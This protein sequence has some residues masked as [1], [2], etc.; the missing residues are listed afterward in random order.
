M[1]TKKRPNAKGHYLIAGAILLAGCAISGLILRWGGVIGTPPP[2][3]EEGSAAASS[4]E[5]PET[6][7]CAVTFY[8]W[9]SDPLEEKTVAQGAPVLPPVLEEENVLF[10]GWSEDLYAVQEDLKVVP[11]GE[12]VAEVTNALCADS[13]YVSGKEP[14]R[15][16]LR[17]EGQ[18]DCTDFVIT[19]AYDAD[20]L[21]FEGLENALPTLVAKND[22]ATGEL[23]LTNTGGQHLRAPTELGKLIFRCTKDGGYQTNLPKTVSEIYTE[24]NGSK[25]YTDSTAYDTNVYILEIEKE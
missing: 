18:V 14:F 10:K 24:H 21:T 22:P 6:T 20:L 16:V 11:R 19:M 8:D 4:S 25:V 13:V 9:K 12:N 7:T 17:M 1:K 3:E 23:V 2:V 5:V 15:V